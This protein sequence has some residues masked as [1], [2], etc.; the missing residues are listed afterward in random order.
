M[1]NQTGRFDEAAVF[2]EKAVSLDSTY[3]K[4]WA[5][6]GFS[7]LKSGR[8]AEA[9]AALKK[10]IG[11]DS[12]F[13]NPRSHLGMVFFKT[14]RPEA[15]RQNFLKAIELDPKYAPAMLGLAYLFIS[16]GKTAEAL[17]Q[18]ERA[19]GNG[20]TFERLEKNEDLAP[21]RALPEWRVMMKKHFPDK[22]KD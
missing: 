9:E 13:A 20:S 17:G 4:I 12:M 19:I 11:I 3:A 15:A 10:S 16:E 18:V 14:K 8:F 22:V 2:S 6:L 7:Y 21:L 1:C 5:S